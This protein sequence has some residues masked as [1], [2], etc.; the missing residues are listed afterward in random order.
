MGHSSPHPNLV[1]GAMHLSHPIQRCPR[2]GFRGEGV[3]YFRRPGH[4]AL[5]AGLG[6]LTYGV[7]GLVYWL[8]KRNHLVCARCGLGWE[9]AHRADGFPP[10]LQGSPAGALVAPPEPPLPRS[11]LG[12]RVVGAILGLGAVLLITMGLVELEYSAVAVGG[13]VGVAAGGSFLWGWTALQERRKALLMRLQRKVLLLAERRGGVL[14]VT[15]VAAELDLSIPA[16][17]RVLI[18]MDDGFRVRSEVTDEGIVLYEFPEL[19]HRRGLRAT[20]RP[21]DPGLPPPP[22]GA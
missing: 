6:L 11:G 1:P 3:P 5:L 15:E 20:S 2:C 8:V 19:R 16:A 10:V 21:E 7:G 14:T 18:T 13:V 4:V 12:R 17:E 22:P 9:Q